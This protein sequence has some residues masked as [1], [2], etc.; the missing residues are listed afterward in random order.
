MKLNVR[1]CYRHK[2]LIDGSL[3]GNGA[4][5]TRP[6]SAL[7]PFTS[8]VIVSVKTSKSL[9]PHPHPLSISNWLPPSAFD[10][11]IRTEMRQMGELP[12][13][14]I[15]LGSA[16]KRQSPYLFLPFHA[17]RWFQKRLDSLCLLQMAVHSCFDS[18][19]SQ[20]WLRSFFH[21]RRMLRCRRCHFSHLI[22]IC[23][24]RSGMLR[25]ELSSR[26]KR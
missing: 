14:Y 6:D 23:R 26:L 12:I 16:P 18:S 20:L 24:W 3:G 2:E 1:R 17:K 11:V 22:E 15:L 10:G 21:G 9:H 5:A 19:F 13:M 7:H 8:H 4:T 25:P